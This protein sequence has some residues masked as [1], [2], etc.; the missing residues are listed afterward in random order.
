LESKKWLGDEIIEFRIFQK[1]NTS[2][3]KEYIDINSQTGLTIER[4]SRYGYFRF[5][6]L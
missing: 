1:I 5:G 3:D 2:K 4:P 6:D